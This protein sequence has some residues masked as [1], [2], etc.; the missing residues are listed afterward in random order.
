MNRRDFSA[1]TLGALLLL[2]LPAGPAPAA[3]VTII[4]NDGAGEGFNDPTPVAPIGGNPGT[5]LGAQRLYIFNYA[6]SIWGSILPSPVTIQ[7]TAQFNSQT[8]DSVSGVLG[9]ASATSV[10]ANFPGAEFSNTWYPQALANK[11][12]GVDQ[13]PTTADINATFNSDVDNSTCLGS[14]NW[15]YGTDG[16]EGTNIELLPVVL[17][18]LGHGLGFATFANASTGQLL[19]N[20]PDVYTHFMLDKSSGLH[21]NEMS[22]VQRKNSAVNTGNLVWDGPAVQFMSQHY[23]Y[24]RPELLVNSPGSV[25]GSYNAVLAGFGPPLDGTGLTANVVQVVD[26]TAPTSDACETIVNGAALNGNIALIDR[27]TC[28]FVFKVKAA[29]NAGAIG[30]IMVNNVAGAPI[31]MG[32]TDPTITIPSVMISQTDGA[33]LKTAL[34]SGTVNATLHLSATQLAGAFPD[35]DVL[36]YAPNPVESGSSLS[37]WDDTAAPDLLMEPFISDSLHDTIDLTRQAFEDIGWLPRVTAVE[38]VASAPLPSFRVRSMPNPFRPS[39]IISLELPT[40]GSTRV[41]VFDIHGRLVK[42]L[43]NNWMPAG[44]HAVTWDGTDGR[45]SRVGAGIYFSRVTSGGRSSSQRLVKLDG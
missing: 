23:L 32:G 45:G 34:G 11:L 39:T 4:N 24:H 27:G 31:S 8:C 9:S 19:S 43:M 17:H 42:E 44:N 26:N 30:V 28:T 2:A 13:G 1:L 10:Y 37:H 29:Q 3:T 12:S 5:T 18:E 21:W 36:L 38:P 35:G 33:T 6:A 25:A 20:T 16:N 40:S 14:S 22:N 15:Y 41:D 7:V